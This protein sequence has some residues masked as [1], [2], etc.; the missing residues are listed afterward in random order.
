MKHSIR[1]ACVSLVASTF[2]VLIV[3]AVQANSFLLWSSTGLPISV[4]PFVQSNPNTEPDGH[5]GAFM[6]WEDYRSGTS[7]DIYAQHVNWGGQGLWATNGVTVS[8]ASS[9]QRYPAIVSDGADGAI[10]AWQDKRN[11]S[12][13]D[14]FAQ[15][16]SASGSPLWAVNGI[17][18]SA[19][20]NTQDYV[21]IVSDNHGGAIIVWEDNRSGNYDIYAQRVSGSGSILWTTNGVGLNESQLF[22]PYPEVASDGAAGVI[23]AWQHNSPDQ[24]HTYI[25]SQHILSTGVSLWQTPG[26]TV[27]LNEGAFPHVIPDGSGGAILAWGSA[28][29][30]AQR[31]SAQGDLLW[32]PNG[33]IVNASSGDNIRLASD[34]LSGAYLVWQLDSNSYPYSEIRAQHVLSNGV[35]AWTTNGISISTSSGYQYIPQIVKDGY[36]GAIVLWKDDPTL[37]SDPIADDII[38]A[39]RIDQLGTRLWLT[40]GLTVISGTGY[41]SLNLASDSLHGAIAVWQDLRN[42]TGDLYAQH[43]SDRVLSNKIYLP[44]G[45]K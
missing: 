11:G 23:A 3:T 38:S 12:D 40:D 14:I 8:K 28:D 9:D 22:K 18:I 17:T 16:I 45:L 41:G 36:N 32:G 27:S 21:R 25:Y 5:G 42:D 19:A 35:R 15:H 7:Y 26:I 30:Y 39:Q 2:L 37:A 24:A 31:I 33:K 29:F 1:I 4:R 43:L 20:L 13:Y 44:L 34:D 6:T 10:V